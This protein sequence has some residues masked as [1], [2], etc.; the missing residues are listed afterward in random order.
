MEEVDEEFEKE[1]AALMLDFK[2]PSAASYPNLPTNNNA[3]AQHDAPASSDTV[4][5]RV[6]MKRGGRDDK[7]KAVQARPNS[8]IY[9]V[10]CEA[11]HVMT[12]VFT[13]ECVVLQELNAYI[14]L[15]C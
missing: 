13:L 4:S 11:L 8:H 2:Q 12:G 3:A 10:H 9:V 14:S 6:M 5:F 1:F 15:Y 7:S